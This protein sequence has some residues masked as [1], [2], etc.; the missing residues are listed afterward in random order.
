MNAPTYSIREIFRSLPLLL[1]VLFVFF[2]PVY[3]W[4]SVVCV[5]LLL[6]TW[7]FSGG[8]GKSLHAFSTDKKLFLFVLFYLVHVIGMSYTS[9]W[10][11]GLQ[12]LE[13]KLS[14]LIFPV[15]L[16]GLVGNGKGWRLIRPAFVAGTVFAVILCLGNACYLYLNDRDPA[17]FFYVSYSFLLHPTYFSMY[18]N[19]SI[20]FLMDRYFMH[21]DKEKS[22]SRRG[23]G[24]LV[25]FLLIN[26]QL[27]SAR[28]A[29]ISGYATLIIYCLFAGRQ[30]IFRKNRIRPLLT[31]MLLVILSQFLL[32]RTSNRFNQVEQAIV[33]EVHS[34]A[35]DT[36]GVS[37]ESNSSN[38][39]IHVWKSALELIRDHPFIGVGTGDIRTELA[40]YYERDKY[41]YGTQHWLNPHNQ[42]FHTTAILGLFGLAALLLYL[43][44]PLYSAWKMKDGLFVSFL[45]LLILNGL[46]ESIFEVQKGVLF[47]AYFTVMFYLHSSR[48]HN[49]G[50][51]RE[52]G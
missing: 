21:G 9:D 38:Q 25:L 7:L 8:A 17:H 4:V 35:S 32:L 22:W 51:G 15:I 13:T 36:S 19:L 43:M 23:A 29:L 11:Y 44:V 48:V 1:Q 39:R 3:Q 49:P 37:P 26:M 46:T 12:D 47:A 42:Y 41:T 18:L 10:Q 24:F 14:F 27:L 50:T 31:G 45:L 40:S 34:S 52:K 30:I 20:L 5:A 16:P 6:L 33:Q 2:L 28:M